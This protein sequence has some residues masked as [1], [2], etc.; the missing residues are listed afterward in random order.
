M[1]T[2]HLRTLSKL[3][4]S[5]IVT[6]HNI[7]FFY[8][9]SRSSMSYWYQFCHPHFKPIKKDT[10]RG[11]RYIVLLRITSHASFPVLLSVDYAIHF[12]HFTYKNIIDTRLTMLVNIGV[13]GRTTASKTTT[14]I[15][16]CNIFAIYHCINNFHFR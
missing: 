6:M 4:P 15:R 8:S 5:L 14:K 9:Y 13:N 7:S 12:I 16:I 1:I 3:F 10:G 11:L 2:V